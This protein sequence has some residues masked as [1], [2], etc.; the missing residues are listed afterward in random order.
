MTSATSMKEKKPNINKRVF[1]TALQPD[2]RCAR[3]P[4]LAANASRFQPL[5]RHRQGVDHPAG[6]ANLRSPIWAASVGSLTAGG[7]SARVRRSA[8]SGCGA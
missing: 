1:E 4:P 6:A 8:R 2:S 3:A 5:G 7:S